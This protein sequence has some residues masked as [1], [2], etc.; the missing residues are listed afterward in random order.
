MPALVDTLHVFWPRLPETLDP[1]ASVTVAV[2][3]EGQWEQLLLELK[4]A[5]LVEDLLS[6]GLSALAAPERITSLHPRPELFDFVRAPGSYGKS[7]HGHHLQAVVGLSLVAEGCCG[8]SLVVRIAIE[9]GVVAAM[10]AF[11][12][13]LEV[14]CGLKVAYSSFLR[15]LGQQAASVSEQGMLHL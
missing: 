14:E 7:C 15:I 4:L 5:A 2:D 13:A 8:R 10:A 9:I 12:L 1:R 3:P 6:S 11:G